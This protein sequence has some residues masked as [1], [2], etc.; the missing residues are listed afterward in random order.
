MIIQCINNRTDE[1]IDWP[2]EASP[3]E[4][5]LG[6]GSIYLVY[7]LLFEKDGL[8]YSILTDEDFSLPTFYPARLFKVIDNRL[9]KYFCL[10]SF[11]GHHGKVPFITFNEWI[12]SE[13]FYEKLVDQDEKT[14]IIFDKYRNVLK[15]EHPIYPQ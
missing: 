1:L 9:S 14:K 12:S 5:I 3:L 10:G 4:E 13:T 6:L 15:E 11:L 7:A 8:Y 2:N